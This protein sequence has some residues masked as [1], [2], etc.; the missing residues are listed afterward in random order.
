MFVSFLT[1]ALLREAFEGVAVTY[2]GG[3][4]RY[5]TGLAPIG[6]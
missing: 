2:G 3:V 1:W 4:L 5:A 6:A